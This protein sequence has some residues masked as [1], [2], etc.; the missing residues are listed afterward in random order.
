MSITRYQERFHNASQYII[1]GRF[2]SL[3]R[4]GSLMGRNQGPAKGRASDDET[5]PLDA[6][7]RQMGADILDEP[8]PERL[9]QLLRRA[10]GDSQAKPNPGRSR[11]GAD[12]G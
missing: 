6:A 8:V 9:R 4:L 5:D 1:L 11:S 12:R 10:R 3:S 7:L 2:Q